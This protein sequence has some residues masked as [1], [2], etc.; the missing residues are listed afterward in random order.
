METPS[1]DSV[2]NSLWAKNDVQRGSL[3]DISGRLK[4]VLPRTL[5]LFRIHPADEEEPAHPLEHTS[6]L[7]LDCPRQCSGE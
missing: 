1:S 2:Q 7:C 6:R 5:Q 4:L 3:R